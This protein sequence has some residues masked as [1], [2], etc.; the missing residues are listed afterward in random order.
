[1]R[2]ER[3][4]TLAVLGL[5]IPPTVVAGLV[6]LLVY[7]RGLLDDPASLLAAT[8]SSGPSRSSGAAPS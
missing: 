1:M 8:R 3:K 5:F 2:L 7:R 6:L 4:L